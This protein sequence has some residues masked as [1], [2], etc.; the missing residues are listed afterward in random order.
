MYRVVGTILVYPFTD[1]HKALYVHCYIRVLY[2]QA[3]PS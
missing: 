2:S 1:T 3:L